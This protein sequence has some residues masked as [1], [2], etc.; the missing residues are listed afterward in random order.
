MALKVKSSSLFFYPIVKL[1]VQLKYSSN[2]NV[3]RNKLNLDNKELKDKS[4]F[5]N[6]SKVSK[7]LTLNRVTGKHFLYNVFNSMFSFSNGSDAPSSIKLENVSIFVKK[8]SKISH[9]TILRAP[10]RYKKGRYQVGFSRSA[11]SVSLDLT[12]PEANKD[13][14]SIKS[15]TQLNSI[16]LLLSNMFSKTSTNIIVLDKMR[17]ILPFKSS[18]FFIISNYTPR[19]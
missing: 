19:R 9:Y 8:K 13:F 17:F 10:Y 3:G 1:R 14:N 6:A 15:L 18:D 4:N 16:K 7:D 11:I 2:Y 12:L 5:K